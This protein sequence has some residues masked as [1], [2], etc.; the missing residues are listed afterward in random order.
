MDALQAS[1][2]PFRHEMASG[3][4]QIMVNDWNFHDHRHSMCQSRNG[5][6]MRQD[7]HERIQRQCH[8]SDQPG[9][10]S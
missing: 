7:L 6:D 1:R 5:T 10:Y 8:F 4:N 2:H 9:L 3:Q